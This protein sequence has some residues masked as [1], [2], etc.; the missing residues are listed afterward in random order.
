MLA[1]CCGFAPSTRMGRNNLVS[2]SKLVIGVAG[3]RKCNSSGI[4]SPL[5]HSWLLCSIHLLC[6]QHGVLPPTRGYYYDSNSSGIP[7]GFI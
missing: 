6:S 5:H 7:C 3:V 2:V 4:F 1:I